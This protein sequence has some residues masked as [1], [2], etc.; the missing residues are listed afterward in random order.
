M[1]ATK[2]ILNAEDGDVA[3]TDW[4]LPLLH[5]D[6]Y[7]TSPEK[8]SRRDKSSEV[9]SQGTIG[10]CVGQSGRNVFEDIPSHRHKVKLSPMWI[11][12]TGK[13]YDAWEGED[14]SGTSITGACK[15]LLKE[16]CCEEKFFP[17]V[18]SE[19]ALPIIG[20]SENASHRKIHAFYK[21]TVDRV[22][23]IKNLLSTESLWV[24]INIHENF[25][26]IENGIIPSDG[27][28]ESK[29]C[30]GHA[31]TLIGWKYVDKI[32][33][34]EFQNSW[35]KNWGD[36]G[37]FFISHLLFSK[38]VKGGIYYLVTKEEEAKRLKKLK[39][40][41][42]KIIKKDKFPWCFIKWIKSLWIF[43]NM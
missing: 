16:G 4:I 26:R 37:Y 15:A 22:I 30:G 11:Y 14:Y 7:N 43:R 17:Y 39:D 6:D 18:F 3:K 34:W 10:S 40:A 29:Y 20:A 2:Y 35:G 23:E 36:D 42:I 41:K 12:Q 24:A 5:A 32:L 27:Y 28:L 19:V 1:D 33:Y 38:I 25:Y 21:L 13:K 9:L 8:F 31:I